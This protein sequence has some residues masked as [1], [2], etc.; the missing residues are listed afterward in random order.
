MECRHKD[1]DKRNCTATNVAWGT[2][3]E[4]EA[5]KAVHGTNPSGERNPMAKLTRAVVAEMRGHRAKTKESYAK[6]GP[7]FGVTAM[8]A[9]R[10]INRQAWREE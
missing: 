9:Y 3:S 4:N 6:I 10:A 2:K 8:T 7:R 1:G 5:D